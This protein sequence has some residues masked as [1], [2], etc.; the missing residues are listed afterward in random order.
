MEAKVGSFHRTL[1]HPR[2]RLYPAL[3]TGLI[4][5]QSLAA[6]PRVRGPG[7]M[8]LELILCPAVYRESMPPRNP[9]EIVGNRTVRQVV[10]NRPKSTWIPWLR[11]RWL[12]SLSERSFQDDCGWNRIF[13]HLYWSLTPFPRDIFPDYIMK[14]FLEISSNVC[15]NNNMILRRRNWIVEAHL[16]KS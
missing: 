11:Y 10:F 8:S 5:L 12:N 15:T 4:R 3:T 7:R 1:V 16:C 9:L 14:V 2:K 6:N 13:L